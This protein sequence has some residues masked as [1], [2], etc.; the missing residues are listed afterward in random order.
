MWLG[1]FPSNTCK[2]Q[3]DLFCRV[4][5]SLTIA[6]R[7]LRRGCSVQPRAIVSSPVLLNRGS[8]SRPGATGV[9]AL[10]RG[11]RNCRGQAHRDNFSLV[12]FD[13]S[14]VV[15]DHGPDFA[16]PASDEFGLPLSDLGTREHPTRSI[17]DRASPNHLLST[18]SVPAVSVSTPLLKPIVRL[19]VDSSSILSGDTDPWRTLPG[20]E[21]I[22]SHNCRMVPATPPG[23]LLIY[24]SFCILFPRYHSES[25]SQFSS[26]FRV[27]F[28]SLAFS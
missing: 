2:F 10:T 18:E 13:G 1:P 12:S 3:R 20:D 9:R 8:D 19:A 22:V 23:A 6:R 24:R 25:D 17:D 27:R 7:W 4:E 15:S 26:S 16:F 5:C 11:S 28:H 21:L 14:F